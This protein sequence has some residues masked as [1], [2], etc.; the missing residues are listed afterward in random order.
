M[1][2]VL[3]KGA[4]KEEIEALK[5]KLVARKPKKQGIT[6]AEFSGVLKLTEDPLGIQRRLRDEWD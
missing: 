5:K 3:K 2:V 6:A 1:V 4:T